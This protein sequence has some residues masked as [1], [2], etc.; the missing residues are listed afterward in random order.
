L[1][2][3]SVEPSVPAFR[4]KIIDHTTLPKAAGAADDKDD[5][6][7]EADTSAIQMNG[8]DFKP[9][10]VNPHFLM[11]YG[12]IMACGKSYQSAIGEF[13]SPSMLP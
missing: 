9:T 12:H 8:T 5:S 1:R 6:G 7:D 4:I 13:P 3:D 2:K 10:K 11:L